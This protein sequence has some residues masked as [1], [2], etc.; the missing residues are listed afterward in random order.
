MHK[1]SFI[2][3]RNTL[4]HVNPPRNPPRWVHASKKSST[5]S[6]AHSHSTVKCDPSVTVTESSPWR[7]PSRVETS[8]SVLRL[9][10]K[11]SLCICWWSV[12]FVRVL[13]FADENWDFVFCF[14]C[15]QCAMETR[16]TGHGI[17]GTWSLS[18]QIPGKFV[19][20]VTDSHQPKPGRRAGN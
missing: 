16:R 4:L 3:N 12:F 7:W 8:R 19:G 13:K 15:F 1:E 6:T 9:M 2:I 10:I 14:C 18:E 11:L 20:Q 5:Q 17:W